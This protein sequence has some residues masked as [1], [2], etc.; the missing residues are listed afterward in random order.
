M[1]VQA[2]TAAPEGPEGPATQPTVPAAP[3]A[4]QVEYSQS[5]GLVARLGRLGAS[6]MVSSYQSGLLYCLGRNPQG[7]LHVHQAAMPTPMGIT[8]EGGGRLTLAGGTQ[9]LRFENVLAPAERI[10][11]TFDACFVPRQIHTTGALDAHDVGVDVE[12]RVI[13]VNTRFNCLA[14]LSERHSFV[15]VW[16]PPFIDRIVDEDRCHLN[17]LA[18]RD[19]QPAYVTAVSRSNTV[20]GWRDRR[21]GGGV[22]IEVATGR[23]VC[24]GLSMPH[25]P[26]WHDGQLWLLNSGTGELGVVEG[27]DGKEPGRFKPRAFCPGFLRGLAFAGGHAIVGL[28]KPR[29]KRFEGLPLDQRL[30]DADSAPWC[31]VQIIDLATGSCV[32]W[33]RIDGDV[34]ELYDVEV[35]PGCATPMVLSPGTPELA[36]LITWDKGTPAPEAAAPGDG[37]PA[38]TNTEITIETP[39]K[40]PAAVKAPRRKAKPKENL[41]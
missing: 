38:R 30:Q 14:T 20:D 2:A 16:Q 39:T 21:D 7:G 35:I 1:N 5:T 41:T 6:L 8:W 33:F 4:S 18:M 24:E 13:F 32:D 36:N 27:L 23:I 10:N 3:A 28:S 40:A 31:G 34:A 25:S 15:P 26:R 12:G 11:T 9:I 17:G 22:V 29:Y 37:A 19:G